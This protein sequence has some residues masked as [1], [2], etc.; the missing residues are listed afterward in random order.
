MLG[1]EILVHIGD[2]T[3]DLKKAEGLHRSDMSPIGSDCADKPAR[4]TCQ[5]IIDDCPGSEP[6]T[7]WSL[8]SRP[9]I[10]GI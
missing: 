3:N 9:R 7:S 8:N 5:G 10:S 1:F 4:V 6:K 2:Y